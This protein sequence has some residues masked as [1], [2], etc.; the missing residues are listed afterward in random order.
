MSETA[1]SQ[2]LEDSMENTEPVVELGQTLVDA[3]TRKTARENGRTVEEQRERMGDHF[4]YMGA[5]QNPNQ[6]QLDDY[7]LRGEK[8]P[9]KR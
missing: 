8:V 5:E 7:E 4:A 1:T 9:V 3:A 2:K 6:K